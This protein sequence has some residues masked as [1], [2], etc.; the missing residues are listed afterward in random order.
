MQKT[1]KEVT[2]RL[3]KKQEEVL[4]RIKQELSSICFS[5][6]HQPDKKIPQIAMSR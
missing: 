5:L 6:K 2:E 1:T 3:D 4:T